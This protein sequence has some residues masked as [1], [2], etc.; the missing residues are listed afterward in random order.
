MFFVFLDV[1]GNL[2]FYSIFTYLGKYVDVYYM[3]NITYYLLLHI[4]NQQENHGFKHESAVQMVSQN[5]VIMIISEFLFNIG[6]YEVFWSNTCFDFFLF[7]LFQSHMPTKTT[8]LSSQISDDEQNVS[9]SFKQI[10]IGLCTPLGFQNNYS[11]T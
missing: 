4:F 1:N 5:L 11:E 8:C 10:H 9:I 2:L 6:R 3:L 7:Q